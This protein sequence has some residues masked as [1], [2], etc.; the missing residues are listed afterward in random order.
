[1]NDSLIRCTAT[2]AALLSTA[3]MACVAQAQWVVTNLHPSGD[4]AWS[5]AS[6]ASGTQQVGSVVTEGIDTFNHAG[7]WSGTAESWIDLGAFTPHGFIET[8]AAS[9]WSDGA[10]IYIAGSGYNTLTG[11]SEALLWVSSLQECRPDCNHDGVLNINDFICFQAE[12]RKKT[13]YGD[14]NGDGKW[15]VNDFIAFQASWRKGC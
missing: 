12:W 11:R 14:Y 2:A 1:M 7:L 4:W 9:I 10:S 3:W 15:N 6:G 13:A 8:A 5:Y